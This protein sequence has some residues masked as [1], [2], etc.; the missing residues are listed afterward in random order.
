MG[1]DW[2]I[3]NSCWTLKIPNFATDKSTFVFFKHD[4]LPDPGK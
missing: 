1:L 4:T 2:D 3:D